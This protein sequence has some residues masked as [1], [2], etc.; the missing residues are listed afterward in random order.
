MMWRIE[1]TGLA[2]RLLDQNVVKGNRSVDR[3]FMFAIPLVSLLGPDIESMI[4]AIHHHEVIIYLAE[5]HNITL[6]ALYA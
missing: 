2:D 6:L 4:F 5:H 1:A 3:I